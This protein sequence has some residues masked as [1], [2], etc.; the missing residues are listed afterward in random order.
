MLAD[1]MLVIGQVSK[2]KPHLVAFWKKTA[3]QGLRSFGSPNR[4]RNIKHQ[5]K[6]ICC[7]W[8]QH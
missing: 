6:N 7:E 4:F 2:K 5:F 1:W 8:G 3:N